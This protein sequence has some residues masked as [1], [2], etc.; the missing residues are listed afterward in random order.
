MEGSGSSDSGPFDAF[1]EYWTRAAL[2]SSAGKQSEDCFAITLAVPIVSPVTSDV[3]IPILCRAVTAA[4]AVGLSVSDKPNL[5]AYCYVLLYS[6]YVPQLNISS[7]VR[8]DRAAS[9]TSAALRV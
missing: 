5:P 9:G 7:R 3:L 6:S 2:S 4:A 1:L 8:C